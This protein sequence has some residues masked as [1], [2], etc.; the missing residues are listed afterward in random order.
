MAMNVTRPFLN[1]I[2]W[3][4]GWMFLLQTAETLVLTLMTDYVV[5]DV[6]SF[7]AV[8]TAWIGF[9]YPLITAVLASITAKACKMRP[10]SAHAFL[11]WAIGF[12]ASLV[13]N[14]FAASID[15]H[16]PPYPLNNSI[17]RAFMH[18][19]SCIIYTLIA[20]ALITGNFYRLRRRRAHA[21]AAATPT[22]FD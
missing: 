8:V 14:L 6:P 5:T 2:S 15:Q 10:L 11:G 13:V 17:V 16:L 18:W 4:L 12:V 9:L 1:F 22:V 21:T 7:V 3:Y 19:E 20:A